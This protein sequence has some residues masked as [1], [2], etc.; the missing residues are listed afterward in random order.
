MLVRVYQSTGFNIQENMNHQC[1]I[2]HKNTGRK[3]VIKILFEHVSHT[4]W[5]DIP[6]DLNHDK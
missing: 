2:T 6:K 3:E 4:A 5:H 1:E